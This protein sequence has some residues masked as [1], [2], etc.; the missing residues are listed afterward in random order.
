[1]QG[2]RRRLRGEASTTS[3]ELLACSFAGEGNLETT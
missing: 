2:L 3:F 1:M